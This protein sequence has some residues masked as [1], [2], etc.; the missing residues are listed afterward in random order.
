MNRMFRNAVT[1]VVGVGAIVG[2]SPT[3]IVNAFTPRGGYE[4]SRDVAYG[5]NARQKIDIYTPEEIADDTPA[6]LFFYGG[7]WQF[8]E[9]ESYLF[10]GQALASRGFIVA[11]AD[12][13]LHPEVRW[14]GFVDDAVAA[15]AM[16]SQRLPD[17]SIVLSGHSA[18]AYLAAMAALDKARQKSV[19]LDGCRIA[20][21]IGLAG[22]YD[23]RPI[24]D[25]DIIDIFGPGEAGPETMPVFYANSTAPPMLLMTGANDRT[26]SPGNTERMAVALGRFGAPVRVRSYD[27]VSHI[28]I[29]ASLSGLARF[30]APTLDDMASF[31]GQLP[32]RPRC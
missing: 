6:I 1:L 14:Q 18:G 4:I 20:G 3:G 24:K 30:V 26:V 31:A 8:G 27:G 21:V 28:G 9:K 25:P 2:C 12:Y 10:V 22:P 13:R 29:V 32:A 15:T 16:L 11:V 7:R 5:D 17:R 23:I 19:G